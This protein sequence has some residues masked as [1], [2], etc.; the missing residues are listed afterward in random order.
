MFLSHRQSPICGRDFVAQKESALT[1]PHMLREDKVLHYYG[2]IASADWPL[3]FISPQNFTITER[4]CVSIV[5]ST[6]WVR[7]PIH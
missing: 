1:E 4:K 6:Q 2:A 3:T 7:L 5:P